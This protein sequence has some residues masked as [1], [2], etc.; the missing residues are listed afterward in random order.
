MRFASPSE[1]G[2]SI[3]KM[4]ELD[5][6]DVEDDNLLDTSHFVA[7]IEKKYQNLTDYL[8]GPFIIAA[9]RMN[10]HTSSDITNSS[11]LS[12]PLSPAH[13]LDFSEDIIALA[14]NLANFSLFCGFTNCDMDAADTLDI[15]VIVRKE[16]SDFVASMNS[17]SIAVDGLVDGF[18]G[19]SGGATCEQNIHRNDSKEKSEY[20]CNREDDDKW[21][22]GA[23]SESVCAPS[24]MNSLYLV[25][26][27]LPLLL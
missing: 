11:S 8:T 20:K 5:E 18:P 22:T 26:V 4:L 16:T 12:P 7:K 6:D 10:L 13:S 17:S 15:S 23:C 3:D 1:Q 2:G 25:F 14:T 9:P 24:C 19:L 27:Y 21:L